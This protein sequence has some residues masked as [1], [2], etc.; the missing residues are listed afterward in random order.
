M[1]DPVDVEKTKVNDY[2]DQTNF[3]DY[4]CDASALLYQQYPAI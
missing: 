3:L 1:N 4:Y 2:A